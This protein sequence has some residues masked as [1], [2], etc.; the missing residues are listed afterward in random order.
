MRDQLSGAILAAAFVL[1]SV[2][3]ASAEWVVTPYAGITW[4]TTATFNDVI[5]SYDDTFASRLGFGGAGGWRSGPLT[6]EFDFGY[7][8]GMFDERITTDSS[9]EFQYGSTRVMTLMANGVWAAPF[10]FVGLQPY[11]AAGI[12]VIRADIDPESGL[13]RVKST[14]TA[15]NVG[16][17]VMRPLGSRYGVRAEARL[18]RTIQEQR[19]EREVDLAI[20]VMKFWRFSGGVT[21]R[22]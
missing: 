18:F 11:G 1:A 8:P 7:L 12:G 4:K 19:P 2:T 6:L 16:G 5:G 21:I 3:P 17:G 15:F 20:A 22:F 10:R 14:N 9:F 13:F